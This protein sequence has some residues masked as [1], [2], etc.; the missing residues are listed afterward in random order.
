M[1][2]AQ[3]RLGIPALAALLPA[4]ALTFG[5]L[6][7]GGRPALADGTP[8]AVGKPAP[9]V[10]KQDQ[11]GKLHKLADKKGKLVAQ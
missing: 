10:K 6:V 5:F 3:S 9:P 1:Y 4:L 7:A 2:R 8:P 11:M